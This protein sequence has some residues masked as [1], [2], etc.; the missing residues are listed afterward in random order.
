MQLLGKVDAAGL[1]AE[2]T[3]YYQPQTIFGFAGVLA[4]V[5]AG[6][7]VLRHQMKK[8]MQKADN[9]ETMEK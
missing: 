4:A 2:A 9:A 7:L 5:G 8:S 1:A 6:Y 3:A